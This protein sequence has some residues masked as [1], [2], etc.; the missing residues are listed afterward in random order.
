VG[1]PRVQGR[2][3][4]AVL[5]ALMTAHHD[6][7]FNP[8]Q[9]NNLTAD[10]LKTCL[11]AIWWLVQLDAGYSEE[12]LQ[13]Q[14]DNAPRLRPGRS[15]K[16][17]QRVQE[18]ANKIRTS[19]ELVKIAIITSSVT[20][21]T[22]ANSVL[23]KLNYPPEIPVF[24]G[25]NGKAVLGALKKAHKSKTFKPS[26]GTGNVADNL[27]A[28][29]MAIWQLVQF[30]AGNA[31]LHL[32]QPD[33][34]SMLRRG[35]SIQTQKRVQKI[36]DNIQTRIEQVKLAIIISIV[37]PITLANDLLAEVKY[38]SAI[39]MFDGGNGVAVQDALLTAFN[40]QIVIP[41]KGKVTAAQ[42]LNVC[43]MAMWQLVGYNAGLAEIELRM[44]TNPG[45]PT[46]RTAGD[47]HKNQ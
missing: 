11:M 20:P 43:L 23:P 9:E 22:L 4:G 39:P 33:N 26:R 6:E 45:P 13:L 29:L 8:S 35:R 15:S 46:S 16:S 14:V 31:E 40:A 5:Q 19:I 2:N 1:N 3:G 38:Q 47:P 18:I 28:C 41:G 17:I 25:Q 36:A 10:N 32:P 27:A 24:N 34:G 42:N 44:L 7:I 12:H 21:I 30:E 37:T